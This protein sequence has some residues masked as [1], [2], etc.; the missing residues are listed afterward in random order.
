MEGMECLQSGSEPDERILKF[1]GIEAEPNG[2]RSG[3]NSASRRAGDPEFCSR[4]R[5]DALMLAA[6][7]GGL[8]VS[9]GA[10][11]PMWAGSGAVGGCSVGSMGDE[12]V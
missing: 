10:Y 5:N 6:H 3:S 7:M 1:G 9:I 8:S 11:V 12:T 4:S 2:G